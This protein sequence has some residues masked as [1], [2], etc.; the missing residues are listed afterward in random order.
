M[1]CPFFNGIMLWQVEN[2]TTPVAKMLFMQ[3][4]NLEIPAFS[5]SRAL[6]NQSK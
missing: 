6:I 3:V 2:N 5:P 1:S 4:L